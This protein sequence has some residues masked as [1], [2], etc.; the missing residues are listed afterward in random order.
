[1]LREAAFVCSGPHYKISEFAADLLFQGAFEQMRE[2]DKSV[3]PQKLAAALG[4]AGTSI[5]T[6]ETGCE[7]GWHFVDSSTV[8]I[9]LD[10]F[11]YT[12][13]RQ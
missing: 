9:G 10:D 1:M 12:L 6:L 5:K 3:D 13:K 2:S 11:A 8:E 7:I 4:F